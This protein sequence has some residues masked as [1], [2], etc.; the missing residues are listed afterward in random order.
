M[1]YLQPNDYYID[2]Y[3]LHTIEECLDYYWSIKDGFTKERVIRFVKYSEERFQQEVEKCLSRLLFVLKTKRYQHKKETI[4]EWMD[5]DRH[6]QELYDNTP[7]PQNIRCLDCGS[8]AIMTFK[9]L[10]DSYETDARMTFMF[11]CTKCKK[12]QALYEDGAEW[13]YDPPKCPKCKHPLETDLKIKGDI[14]T[15]TSKCPKCGYKDKNVDDH[16]KF[17]QEQEAKEKREKE[18][19]EKH[20]NDFCLSD[21]DG[22]EYIETIEAMEVAA[23]V[24]EEEAQKYGGPVYE[25]SL[26]LKKTKIS[27]LE[28]L[29]TENLEKAK[30]TKLVFD[31]PEIGQY[32]IV[33]FTVQDS[34][35]SRKD[36]DS[37]LELEKL[38]KDTLEDTNW[39][40][41]SNSIIYRLGYLEG[42]LKGYEQEEDMLKLAGQKEEQKPKSKI[43]DEK[44][45]KYASNNLVQL[46][47]MLGEFDGV[48]NMRKRR[49]EKEPDGFILND[50]GRGYTCGIC[51][52]SMDGDKTWWDLRGIRCLDCQQNLKACIVPLEIFEDEDYGYDLVVKDNQMSWDYGIHSATVRK[53]CRQG[54]LKGRELKRENGTV[55][56]TLFVVSENKEFFEKHPKKESKIKITFS[57]SDRKP[58]EL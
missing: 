33:P 55:Y 53:L 37:S 42:Q 28:K 8:S 51:G 30:Y 36:R 6:M 39:R 52:E 7:P 12:R 1:I 5:R 11:E 38:I 48:E 14:T 56:K 29:L 24:R 18:L 45:Q 22:Q 20:R 23:V 54:E 57:G 47:K 32:V 9:D 2:R 17:W 41:L 27:D 58:T 4:Q 49:L 50:D 34:D 15:F 16:S 21:K 40:L 19:L 31:K 35:S 13:K 3:D 43:D 46:S 44:R 10:H 26:Q 25:R